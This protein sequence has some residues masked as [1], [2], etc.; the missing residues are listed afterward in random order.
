MN[1]IIKLSFVIRN[2]FQHLKSQQNFHICRITI[3]GIYNFMKISR[4]HFN[5]VL[6]PI[7]H[8]TNW[9]FSF[10]F[11]F[12]LFHYKMRWPVFSNSQKKYFIIKTSL[13]A[14]I[15]LWLFYST[16][17]TKG[18]VTDLNPIKTCKWSKNNDQKIQK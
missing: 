12:K 18:P 4:K 2:V 9:N 17:G 6:V 16:R 14:L 7:I 3:V 8:K 10:H 15:Q 1:A 13:I 5:S 11:S